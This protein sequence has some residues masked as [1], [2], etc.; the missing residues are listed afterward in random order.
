MIVAKVAAA[1]RG[2]LWEVA[3]LQR[4]KGMRP[5]IAATLCGRHARLA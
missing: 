3:V 2:T 1:H 5:M 4:R